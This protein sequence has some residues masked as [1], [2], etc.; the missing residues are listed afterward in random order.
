MHI[1]LTLYHYELKKIVKRRLVWA[2]LFACLGC[3][4]MAKAGNLSGNYYVDGKAVDTHYHIFQ[5]DS[6]YL[7]ALSGRV[8]GQA[9]LDETKA[10]YDKIPDSAERYTETEEYQ[11]YARPYDGVFQLIWRWTRQNPFYDGWSADEQDLY[12]ARTQWQE[13]TWTELFLSDTE[14]AFWRKKEAQ[15]DK[16]FTY[17]YHG[18][19]GVILK[20]IETVGI[21]MLLLMAVCLSGIFPEEHMRRTDQMIL[22]SAKG[23]TVEYWAKLSAGIS[24]AFVG[25]VL[26][27]A[28][29]VTAAL[30]IYGTE[31]FWTAMQLYL[32][33][34]TYSYPLSVGQSCLIVYGI[35]LV[36]AVFMSVL[37]MVLSELLHNSIAT[38]ALF[39]GATV[40]GAMFS[41]PGQYRIASQIWQS[42][43]AK[44]LSC[45]GVFSQRLVVIAGH[46]FTVWQTVPV[47]YLLCGV[48]AAMAGVR[49]YGRYQ[50]A[51]R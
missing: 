18:G 7:R 32:K 12:G 10:A 11:K 44:F 35:F 46:C 15:L 42:L 3:I 26:M 51:G 14:K 34:T 19:Y 48:A 41:I 38:M 20:D 40:A 2:A 47:L 5:V 36:T 13:E 16:P 33:L 1:F 29:A 49:I 25:A 31:G 6:A 27:G 23:R 21:L 24:V 39:T 9:L 17:F 8:V 45:N 37:I 28:A 4:A 22:S 43:P 50:V 30:F